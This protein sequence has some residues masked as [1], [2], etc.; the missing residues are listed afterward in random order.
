MLPRTGAFIATK[1]KPAVRQ[2]QLKGALLKVRVRQ[3]SDSTYCNDYIAGV[4]DVDAD[5]VAAT[6]LLTA[7]L[8]DAGGHV[9]WS[10]G[11]DDG[12]VE[13]QRQVLQKGQQ[14]YQQP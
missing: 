5:E 13:L 9:A 8:F 11:S 14:L 2:E 4:I 3:R 1:D 6:M 12:E 10:N 7:R